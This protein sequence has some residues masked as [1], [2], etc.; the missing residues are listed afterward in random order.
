MRSWRRWVYGIRVNTDSSQCK[1][2]GE[3]DYAILYPE[4]SES[5]GV[6]DGA[7]ELDEMGDIVLGEERQIV[8]SHAGSVE[9]ATFDLL[10]RHAR[11]RRRRTA[12]IP[13]L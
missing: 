1:E 10:R 12:L 2:L 7:L 6:W 8:S 11:T 5:G 9:C 3:F 4:Y 13:C